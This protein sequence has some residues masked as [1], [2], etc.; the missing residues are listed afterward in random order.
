MAQA[1]FRRLIAVE[2]W[3]EEVP[4]RHS[5]GSAE[6]GTQILELALSKFS[7]GRS[8]KQNRPGLSALDHDSI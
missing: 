3:A 1:E 7:V 4:E 6:V 5:G 8:S 2:D